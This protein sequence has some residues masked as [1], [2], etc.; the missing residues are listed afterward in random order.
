MNGDGRPKGICHVEFATKESAIAAIESASEE[1][2]HLLGRDLRV[3]FS[4]GNRVQAVTPPSEKL[5][6]SGCDGDEAAVRNVFKQFGDSIIDI[7]LCMLF[8]LSD[9]VPITH[10]DE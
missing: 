7:H 3:D 1:P 9:S 5:Y 8:T 4:A 2:V 10:M 6:F